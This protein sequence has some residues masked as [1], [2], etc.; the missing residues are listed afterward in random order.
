MKVATKS[1]AIALLFLFLCSCGGSKPR[2]SPLYVF[3]AASLNTA[4]ADFEKFFEQREKDVD[5]RVEVSGS[6][7]AARKVSEYKRRGDIVISADRRIIDSLLIPRFADW[8][9][10]FLSNEIVLAYSENSRRAAQLSS[11]NW[12]QIL[13]D[14][15][16][17]VARTDEN[18]GPLGY[19]T[20]LVW[21][22][23]D[24]HYGKQLAGASLFEELSKR[25][26]RKLIRPDA[27]ELLPVLGTEAD[28]VFV[29]RSMARDQNLK[30]ILLPPEV[31]LSSA[32]HQGL[33]ARVSVEISTSPGK[34]MTVRGEPILFSQTILRDS[35]SKSGAVRFVKMLLG[36]EGRAILQR[37]G[38]SPLYPPRLYGPKESLPDELREVIF[39]PAE[40]TEATQ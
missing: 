22:L 31:N 38:F 12:V 24:V 23:A 14:P 8:Q 18:L 9:I 39:E 11:E 29:Y 27:A 35:A 30:H 20:L 15:R 28:Y 37:H 25:V 16:V 2:R 4:L 10:T 1:L 19:Q 34:S 40:D 17:R 6:L 21:K 26:S 3:A 13:L 32:A 5:V 7:I 33:Y 36:S